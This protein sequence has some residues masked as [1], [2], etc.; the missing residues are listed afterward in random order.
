VVVGGLALAVAGA[1][2]A[3]RIVHGITPDAALWQ[4][5][6]EHGGDAITVAA[7]VSLGLLAGLVFAMLLPSHIDLRY[8]F[9]RAVAACARRGFLQGGLLLIALALGL[10]IVRWA[11]TRGPTI[12]P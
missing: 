1:V 11:R 3:L 5:L 9:G 8:W 7:L 10:A 12:R 4:R 2:W 6:R